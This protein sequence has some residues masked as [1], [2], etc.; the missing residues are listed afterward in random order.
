M[1]CP[2]L[3]SAGFLAVAA[4]ATDPVPEPDPTLTA[5]F[6][7]ATHDQ[8]GITLYAAADLVEVGLYKYVVFA[9]SVTNDRCQRT[10]TPSD[11]TFVNCG[12]RE[13]SVRAENSSLKWP[14]E[15]VLADA[16]RPE[17]LTASA[18]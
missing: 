12:A 2:C 1:K 13:G 4:C 10:G 14:R 18:L 8:L 5:Q 9:S 6:S 7:T 17:I 15:G 11:V 3:A 16:A